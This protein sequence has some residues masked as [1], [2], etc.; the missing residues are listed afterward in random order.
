MARRAT[1][2][3]IATPPGAG[4]RG[5]LRISGPRCAEVLTALCAPSATGIEWRDRVAREARV[6]DGIG[7]QPA[8]IFWMPGPRSPTGEDVGEVHG[9]GAP[10]LIAALLRR[11]LA[12]GAQVAQPGEFTRRAFESGRIELTRAEGVLGLVQA[13]NEGE[14]RAAAALLDGGLAKRIDAMREDLVELRAL[15]EAG[16]DFDE[17]DSGSIPREELDARFDACEASLREALAWEQARTAPAARPQAVLVGAT[18]AGKSSLFNRLT[19]GSALVSATAGTTRDALR[20]VWNSGGIEWDLWDLAGFGAKA[21]GDANVQAIDTA[22][23][24]RALD[25]IASAD[26]WIWVVGPTEVDLGAALAEATDARRA[27]ACVGVLA[28]RDAV[29]PTAEAE[30]AAE[31]RRAA[32]RAGIALLEVVVSS[33]RRGRGLAELGFACAAALSGDASGEPAGA[34]SIREV[35]ERHRAALAA[36]S[37]ELAEAR[38]LL[39]DRAPLDLVASVLRLACDELDQ[40]QGRTTPEDLLDRIFARFC[41]GK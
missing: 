19:G 33:A 34:G 28:Q 10:A 31:M 5:V 16:L 15:C 27:P 36:C 23:R 18:N 7:E 35:S 11:A 29:E 22:A 9:P 6:F 14:R 20:G 21:E 12:L 3:A 26:L 25:R 1:I 37:R 4:E 8:W 41:L 39:A 13:R 32:A 40:I 38:R 17:G 24:A 30:L 2:A